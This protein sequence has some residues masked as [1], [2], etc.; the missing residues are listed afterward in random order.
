MPTSFSG[1]ATKVEAE[2][3]P[4]MRL[5]PAAWTRAD[6]TRLVSP[7]LAQ[8]FRLALILSRDS[9]EAEDLL[10][11]SL[12]KAY[13]HRASYQG[14]GNFSAWLYGIVRN[15]HAETMRALKRRRS[16]LEAALDRFGDLLD[17]MSSDSVA[18]SDPEVQAMVQEESELLLTCLRR[19]P[20]P[21]RT[22][23]HLCDVEERSY[24]E[25]AELLEVPVGTV[26]SRH[27][28]G[29]VKLRK[30]FDRVQQRQPG[31]QP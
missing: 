5:D 21:Y 12:V 20:E 8:L 17:D 22:V 15:E 1:L 9:T 19:I 16:L 25:V 29:R 24:E 28:R 3:A 7:H 11:N 23:V 2:S 31:V 30:I 4:E 13:V 14:R 27:A 18:P 26:K 6:F 10:Q